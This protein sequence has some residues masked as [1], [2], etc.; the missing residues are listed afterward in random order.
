MEVE[1]LDTPEDVLN[2]LHDIISENSPIRVHGANRFPTK[3]GDWRHIELGK[4][5]F[6]HHNVP[7]GWT[8]EWAAFVRAATAWD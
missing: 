6:V 1:S 5:T 2:R 7:R 4:N 3:V 8:E